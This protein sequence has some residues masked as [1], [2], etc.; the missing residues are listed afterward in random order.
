MQQLSLEIKL[1]EIVTFYEHVPC[2][3]IWFHLILLGSIWFHVAP[4][5]SLW[6][7]LAT[8]GSVW[9]HVAPIGYL[10]CQLAT[11]GFVWFH[12]VLCVSMQFHVLLFGPN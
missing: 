4:S 2:V 11:F 6:C 7:H 12:L 9:F 10:W 3:P 5:G 8:F 1:L